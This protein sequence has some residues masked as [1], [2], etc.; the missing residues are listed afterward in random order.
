MH[1]PYVR[2]CKA[3]AA[4]QQTSHRVQ[5]RPSPHVTAYCAASD[6]NMAVFCCALLCWYAGAS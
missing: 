4:C 1:Q 5:T 2:R 6:L 3:L